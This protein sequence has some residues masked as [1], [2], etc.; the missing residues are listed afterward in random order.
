MVSCPAVPTLANVLKTTWSYEPLKSNGSNIQVR[1]MCSMLVWLCAALPYFC[2]RVRGCPTAILALARATS[3]HVQSTLVLCFELRIRLPHGDV[4]TLLLWPIS[5]HKQCT[6][7]CACT[8]VCAYM[9]VVGSHSLTGH[10]FSTTV[11]L[12]KCSGCSP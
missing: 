8:C 1:D 9:C 6:P 4:F 3:L 11:T 7:V 5:L 2:L 12:F 10:R